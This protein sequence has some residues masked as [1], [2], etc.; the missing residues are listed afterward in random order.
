MPAGA[1][2]AWPHTRAVQPTTVHNAIGSIVALYTEMMQELLDE[3]R[4]KDELLKQALQQSND[5]RVQMK[6]K[7]AENEQLK[8]RITELEKLLGVTEGTN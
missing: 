6:E 5:V 1:G 3:R 7:E 2:G 4:S 8:A